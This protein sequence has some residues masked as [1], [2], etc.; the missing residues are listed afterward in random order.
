MSLRRSLSSNRNAEADAADHLQSSL[1][2][3]RLPT[4][5]SNV[6]TAQTHTLPGRDFVSLSPPE[7]SLTRTLGAAE[8]FAIT[9]PNYSKRPYGKFNFPLLICVN[10]DS[11]LPDLC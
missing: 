4:Y 9:T 10:F 1:E 2:N 11:I 3:D 5:T 8:T 7:S 6:I